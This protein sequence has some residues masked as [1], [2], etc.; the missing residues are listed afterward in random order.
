MSS[1]PRSASRHHRAALLARF[2]AISAATSAL[3]IGASDAR[4]EESYALG[5]GLYVSFTF[6]EDLGVGWGAEGHGMGL[7]DNDTCYD[8][9]RKGVGGLVQLGLIN[10]DT[11]RYVI[12]AQ[13]GAQVASEESIGF[14]GELGYAGHVGAEG[15]AAGLHT[16]LLFQSPYY[17]TAFARAEWFL[18]EYSIGLG[19]R[20]PST[21][22]LLGGDCSYGRPWRGVDGACV[23]PR[24]H[25]AVDDP[26]LRLFAE[27]AE[28][29]AASV[30]A[31][32]QLAADLL[33]HGAP[34][35]LVTQALDAAED[36]VRH[37]RMAA[38]LASRAGARFRPRLPQR[39]LRRPL[40][41]TAG[42]VRLGVESWLDGCLGEGG[43]ARRAALGAQRATDSRTA[44]AL[45]T[46]A[47]DEERH[48]ELGWSV[49]R[50]AV[51]TEPEAVRDTVAAHRDA[52]LPRT[53]AASGRGMR[54]AGHVLG[55]AMEQ[56]H[57]ATER[58]ARGRLERLLAAR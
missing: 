10:L 13:G 3:F 27:A 54:E 51:A 49:L 50:W 32:L 45:H 5:G 8:D 53:S 56:V 4:A 7:I 20:G 46:I 12:A 57:E 24:G 11:F 2:A 22:G 1:L 6:G 9:G 33:A 26:S 58:D 40:A 21:F 15:H 41:G 55:A 30:P 14:V 34:D 47:L 28:A 44:R 42:R 52:A 25:A 43:A 17:M 29:E 39:S 36:E 37:A 31:F 35:A 23:V 48:A 38:R 16:G 18:D 19:V